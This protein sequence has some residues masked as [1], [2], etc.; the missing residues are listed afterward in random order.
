M[1]SIHTDYSNAE[2]MEFPGVL[3]LR[4]LLM[5]SQTNGQLA[6]FEDIVELGKRT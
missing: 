3:T 1:K 2:K 6:V 5:S 4:V